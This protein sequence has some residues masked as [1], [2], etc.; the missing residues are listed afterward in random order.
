[1]RLPLL[2]SVPHA[3]LEIPLEV[4]ELSNLSAHEIA[5]DG[6]LG[7]RQIYDVH[8]LVA[9]YQTTNIARAFVDQNRADGDFSRDGVI[10]THTCWNVP[11]YRRP[12]TPEIVR[13]LLD[14]YYRPYHQ[15]LRQLVAAGIILGVDCHTM[16]AV[17]PPVGPDAGR[18]RPQVCLSNANST[19]PEKWLQSM[20]DC[21]L[22]YFD[23]VAVN[24]P[25]QGGFIIRS[26]PGGIP[27]LQIEL[28]RASFMEVD[29]K[30]ECVIG[31]LAEW[32]EWHASRTA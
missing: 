12:P 28:S 30:R 17:G 10:K 20:R 29:E 14:N 24:D 2:V 13:L 15:R 18:R 11:I 9:G 27:W 5:R 22:H 6:D 23:E 16:A 4:A 31:A 26:Q 32:C 8:K 25:F 7:A 3:G 1:M 19:C 21:F